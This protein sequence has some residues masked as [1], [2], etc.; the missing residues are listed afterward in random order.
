MSS[1]SPCAVKYNKHE[2]ERVWK[3]TDM[4]EFTRIGCEGDSMGL[5]VGIETTKNTKCT[6]NGT[7]MGVCGSLG[8]TK[9]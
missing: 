6:K 5:Q 9:V 4:H 3:D 1:M 2:W 8:I 7:R